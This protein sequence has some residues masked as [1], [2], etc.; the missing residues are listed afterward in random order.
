MLSESIEEDEYS[1]MDLALVFRIAR[2]RFV[3]DAGFSVLNLF[4]TE[5]IKYSN[6]VMIPSDQTTTI[7]LHAEAVPRTFTVF[8]NM[9][10]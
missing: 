8:L 6:F 5:N 9:A 7:D 2:S 10:F 3:F 1:R 4:N